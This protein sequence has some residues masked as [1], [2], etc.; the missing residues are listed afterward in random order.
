MIPTL[1]FRNP[2]TKQDITVF[3]SQVF[4]ITYMPTNLCTALLSTGGAMVPVDVKPEEAEQ[5]IKDAIMASINA[6]AEAPPEQPK[7]I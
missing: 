6:V 7:E 1:T 3:V 2:V 5:M 4:A